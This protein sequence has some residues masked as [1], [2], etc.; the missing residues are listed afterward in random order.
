MRRIVWLFFI[1]LAVGCAGSSATIKMYNADLGIASAYGIREQV[2]RLLINK[3]HYVIAY[4]DETNNRVYIETDW[5]DRLPFAD[6]RRMGVEQAKSRIII[7]ARTRGRTGEASR[8]SVKFKGENMLFF[9]DTGSWERGHMT[10]EA[11]RYFKEL[12]D[13][14]KTQFAAMVREY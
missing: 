9:A 3:Y 1:L 14:L 6:E 11:R 2:Q 7:E 10:K 5:L 4:A 12:A 8:L 13:E